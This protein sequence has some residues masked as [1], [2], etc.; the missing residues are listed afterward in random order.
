MRLQ[1]YRLCVTAAA[2]HTVKALINRTKQRDGRGVRDGVQ[3]ECI[4]K[5][6]CEEARI[7]RY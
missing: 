3:T 5:G 1:H 4:L 6:V 7:A 2:L